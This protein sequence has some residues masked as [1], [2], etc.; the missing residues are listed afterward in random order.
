MKSTNHNIFVADFETTPYTQYLK[1]G[2]TRVWLF[3]IENIYSSE[4]KLGLT[5]DKFMKYLFSISN[6]IIYFHN[7]SFDGEFIIHWLCENGYKYMR[8]AYNIWEF[9]FF[10]DTM[11]NIY[12]IKINNNN[13]IIFLKCSLKLIPRSLDDIAKEMGLVDKITFKYDYKK[14]HY[15]KTLTEVAINEINY[16]KNDVIVIKKA[17]QEADKIV[18]LN[19][20]TIA[21]TSY[22]IWENNF[23]NIRNYKFVKWVLSYDENRMLEKYYSGGIT[24]L[25]PKYKNIELNQRIYVADVNSLYPFV[26]TNFS[27]PYPHPIKDCDNLCNN[28]K[29]IKLYSVEVT[30]FKI[31]EGFVPFI[32][33][34]NNWERTKVE[35]LSEKEGITLFNW[36]EIDLYMFKKFYKFKNIKIKETTCF[37]RGGE[38]MF[39]EYVEYF[40]DLKTKSPKKSWTYLFAKILLNA[41]Y[42]KHGTRLNKPRKILTISEDNGFYGIYDEKTEWVTDDEYKELHIT[43][44]GK[45]ENY[46]KPFAIFITS[47][48]R[49]YLVEAIQKNREGFV[50][51]D[52]DSIHS[53]KPLF[54]NNIDD[55]KIG[56]WKLEGVKHN[57]G[58]YYHGGKYICAKRYIL[59]HDETKDDLLVKISG[60]NSKYKHLVTAK[61]FNVGMIYKGAK[62][63]RKKVKG[64]YVLIES[65]F[66]LKEL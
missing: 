2:S 17:L 46:F 50:Y 18:G 52:T 58:I 61:N 62:N 51:C 6:P 28:K 13:N 33:E 30:D 10:K 40:Y 12:S 26:M 27:L 45:V 65:D 25:N 16:I 19:Y 56:Y 22:A 14:E 66:T 43:K 35:Y 39:K 21:S 37:K 36:T 41:L 49:M 53:V 1:E 47:Y 38:T 63:Q 24:I 64:G 7:L 3:Y 29:H 55:N 60:L 11:N 57:D 20:L 34:S 48:A 31:I 15:E 32:S 54:L 5:I 23:N 42:G 44:K 8:N 4:G 59:Y 9:D